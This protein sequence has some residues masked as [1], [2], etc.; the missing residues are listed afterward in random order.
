MAD[1][2]PIL[3]LQTVV[4][5]HPVRI[6]GRRYTI[7]HTD[8]LTLQ[9]SLQLEKWTPTAG[10]LLQKVATLTKAEHAELSDVLDRICRLV[11]DAPP[12]VHR[13]LRDTHRVAVLQ[14]F[15]TLRLGTRGQTGATPRPTRSTGETSSRGSRTST[16]ATPPTGSA[17]R[18]SDS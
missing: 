4:T 6:D 5:G 13:A 18:R 8:S 11:L 7:R 2:T 16:R 9:E 3:D 15:I 12:A 1:P 10:A 17:P 14:A